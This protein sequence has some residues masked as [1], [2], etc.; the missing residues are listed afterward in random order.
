M[1]NCVVVAVARPT[2][3]SF[4]EELATMLVIGLVRRLFASGPFCWT[5]FA[6]GGDMRL[7]F[8]WLTA[9]MVVFHNGADD[10]RALFV[11]IVTGIVTL[12]NRSRSP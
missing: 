12:S 10:L 8:T 2:D 9:G 7:L 3:T 6:L 1:L 4:V 11:G 5:I